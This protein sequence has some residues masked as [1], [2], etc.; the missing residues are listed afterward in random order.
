MQLT[1]VSHVEDVAALIVSAIGSDA[2]VKQHF[3][4]CTDRA[5][6][7]DGLAHAVAR[8]LGRDGAD[9]VHYDPAALDLPKAFFPFRAVH[10]FASP[11]KAK[12]LLGWKPLGNSLDDDLATQVQLY[13]DAGRDAADVDFAVD[14]TI[15]S[16]ADA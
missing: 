5:V 13:R 7:L 8:A 1:S 4:A 16:A 12:R 11:D 10:F 15:L 2:A 9:I 14:D 6:T 3:N